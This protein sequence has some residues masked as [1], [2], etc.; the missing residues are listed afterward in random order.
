V[1][2]DPDVSDDSWFHPSLNIMDPVRI[3]SL[4]TN[5]IRDSRKRELSY[6]HGYE[7]RNLILYF[8]R[9]H[10]VIVTEILSSGRRNG[11]EAVSGALGIINHVALLLCSEKSFPLKSICCIMMQ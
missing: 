11:A 8:Y 1:A 6:S 9:K 10:I 7:L 5:G 3:C 4:N 2:V